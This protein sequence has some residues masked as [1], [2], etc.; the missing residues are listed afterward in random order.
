MNVLVT[1]GLGVNGCWVTRSLLEQGHRPI[2][3]DSRSDLTLLSDLAGQFEVVVGDILDYP[4]LARTLKEYQIERICHL[5]AMYPEPANANPV[6]G[7]E[8]NA[9]ATVYVLEAARLRGIDRVVYTSSIAALSSL[10]REHKYPNYAPI[11]EN[12]PSYPSSGGVYGATKIASE[13][14]GYVYQRLYDVKFIALRFAGIF[15]PGKR[16]PRHGTYGGT[17]TQLVENTITATP[18]R[19][20]VAED[21]PKDMTYAR[22]VAQSVVL[23]CFA[24]DEQVKHALFHIGSGRGHTLRDCAAA[25]RE[26][27]PD[28]EIDVEI[29]PGTRVQ[30]ASDG[31]S[32]GG[33]V[34]DIRRAQ[35]ELG[36]MPQFTL[37]EA[38]RDWVEWMDRLRLGPYSQPKVD[39][40]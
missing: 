30:H 34:F 24:P 16:D 5:A 26:S 23:S 10:T 35:A 3:F 1:G 12:H 29:Q 27:F 2:V 14:M 37:E 39:K 20:V 28:A 11:A 6:R 13:L 22:D 36:Y 31:G 15:G 38:V 9:L 18:T 17:W 19:F 32:R 40:G 25:V 4:L 33:Y 7:F 21:E 8:I